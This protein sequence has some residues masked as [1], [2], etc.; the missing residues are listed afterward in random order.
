MSIESKDL[1]A[2]MDMIRQEHERSR[3][4]TLEAV[5]ILIK[6]HEQSE[7]D[8]I[9]KIL[10]EELSVN[11]EEEHKFIQ[12]WMSRMDN[13]GTGFFSSIGKGLAALVILGF[14]AAAL[15]T[16]GRPQ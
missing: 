11:H 14:A 16:M 1:Q 5:K 13:M 10:S 6:E 8:N 9:K 2:L 7:V 3:R 12:M 15:V 4:D